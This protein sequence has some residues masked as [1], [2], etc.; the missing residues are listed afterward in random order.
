MEKYSKKHIK[1]YGEVNRKC[2]GTR[3]S[4]EQHGEEE[5]RLSFGGG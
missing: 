2:K 3:R 4:A 5:R 1:E